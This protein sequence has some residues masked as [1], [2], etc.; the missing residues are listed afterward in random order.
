VTT[1]AE[2]LVKLDQ[3]APKLSEEEEP[4]DR[5]IAA[6]IASKLVIVKEVR[7]DELEGLPLLAT[8][9]TIMAIYL[10]GACQI[11]NSNLRLPGLTTWLVLRT[12]PLMDH[13]HSRTIRK[14]YKA[15]LMA[16]APMGSI[17]KI[18]D[19]IVS[20]D[21]AANDAVGYQQALVTYQNNI[22]SIAFYEAAENIEAE[23][24][25]M[26]FR[27]AKLVAYLCLL[28]AFYFTMKGGM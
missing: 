12:L 4:F 8:N 23:S 7:L 13:I 5:H 24:T 18:A 1:L 19:L 28:G 3:L 25:A 27:I 9:K 26:G 11:K 16:L 15:A 21:Y 6:F 14:K 22:N 10:L 2:L 17:L 20:A